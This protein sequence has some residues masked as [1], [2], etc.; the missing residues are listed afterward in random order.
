MAAHHGQE[1]RR[2]AI[3]NKLIEK[4]PQHEGEWGMLGDD[5]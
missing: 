5:S 2:A 3:D 1:N 4:G